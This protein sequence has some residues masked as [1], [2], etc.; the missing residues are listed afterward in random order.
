MSADAHR[1]RVHR[2]CACRAADG[3]QLGPR[4]PALAGSREHGS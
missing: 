4:C 1:D 3:K 2:R